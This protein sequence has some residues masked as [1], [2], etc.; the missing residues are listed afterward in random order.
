MNPNHKKA[1]GIDVCGKF[2]NIICLKKNG[3]KIILTYSKQLPLAKEIINGETG[4]ALKSLAGTLKHLKLTKRLSHCEA[5]LCVCSYPELLQI[6]KLPD[7]APQA[8]IKFIQDEIRQ[9]AVLP[10]KNIKTDYCMLQGNMGSENRRVL[11]GACQPEPFA[12]AAKELEKIQI[13]VNLVE[14][15]I[16]SLIRA[17]YR[18]VIMQTEHKNTIF[19][20]LRDDVINLCV[21]N[22]SKF[23]F[24]RTKKIDCNN[25][26]QNSPAEVIAEQVESVIQYYEL[27]KASDQNKWQLF[28]N[29]C[30]HTSESPRMAEQLKKLTNRQNLEIYAIGPEHIGIESENKNTVDFSVVAVGAAMKL[31]DC[32]DSQISINMIPDELSEIR[33]SYKHFLMIINTAAV[34]L[35][36]LFLHIAQLSVK[37][38]EANTEISKKSKSRSNI[39]QLARVEEDVNS[40]TLQVTKQINILRDINKDRVWNNLANILVDISNKAPETIQFHTIE[41]R[42]SGK[43]TIDGIAVSYDAVN[44]FIEKLAACK[45]ISSTQITYVKQN[46]LYGNGL[47]DFSI[48]CTLAEKDN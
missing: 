40:Q 3:R 26:E 44:S 19:I 11:V 28:L 20:L 10:L 41:S 16:V 12:E 17:C 5:G 2:V 15:A 27:E 24:L 25:S 9:Y 36:L 30:P 13:D 32:N 7:S 34:I 45:S 18:K 38:A 46:M 47:V 31:L 1:I 48:N 21:F 29:C 23:D 43:L 14:P 39:P 8:G 4:A 22:G 33:K 37:T 6:F 42:I 35:L